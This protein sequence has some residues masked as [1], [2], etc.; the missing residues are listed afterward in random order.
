MAK[1][2]GAEIKR[3]RG[4]DTETEKEDGDEFESQ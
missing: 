2:K 1:K 4:E 3:L